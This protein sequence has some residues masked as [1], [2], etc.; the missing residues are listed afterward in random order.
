MRRL[1]LRLLARV[2]VVALVPIGLAVLRDGTGRVNRVMVHSSDLPIRLV[3]SKELLP[4]FD[5]L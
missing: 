2:R 1:F 4:V 3:F 5:A